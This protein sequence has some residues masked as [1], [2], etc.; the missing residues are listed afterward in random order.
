MIF[1]VWL[2]LWLFAE[3]ASAPLGFDNGL[4]AAPKEIFLVELLNQPAVFHH[5]AHIVTD[6]G[7][8]EDAVLSVDT[9]INKL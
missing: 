8:H 9:L 4:I 6:S 5:E 7:K 1:N 3:F 2:M